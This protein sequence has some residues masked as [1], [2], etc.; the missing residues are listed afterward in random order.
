MATSPK[1]TEWL[2]GCRLYP[3]EAEL[4]RE[5]TRI[6]RVKAAEYI[7]SVLVDVSRRRIARAEKED[8]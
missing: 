5:A 4:I 2:P 3:W 6:E 8:G 7:R 1:R